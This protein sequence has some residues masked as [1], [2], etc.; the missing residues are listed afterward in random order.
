MVIHL[1]IPNPDKPFDLVVVGEINPD[2]ILSGNITPAFGQVE[3]MIEGAILT[4]GSSSAIFA[5]GAARL[6]LKVAFVGKIG[7]DVFGQFMRQQLAERGIDVAGM[8]VDP[9]IRTGLSVILSRGVDRAILT[10]SG[11]I[12]ALRYTEIDLGLLD[13]ARHLHLG[14]YFMLDALR[15][16]VPRLFAEAHNRGLTISLD[17]NYDPTEYWDGGLY[18]SLR[19]VDIFL[20]NETELCAIAGSQDAGIALERLAQSVPT[21]A[22][23]LGGKGALARQ[24]G[25]TADV[26]A[27]PIDVVDTTGAGDTFDAGFVYGYLHGWDLGRTLRLACACGSLS[28]RAA[29]GTAAQPTV[30]EAEAAL[31]Y[32]NQA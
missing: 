21:I 15:P 16:D 9:A 10:Y 20:P 4:I 19:Y 8:A 7:D 2:L 23:K 17:T 29:G 25:Q 22:V 5:C 1:P 13:K 32:Y 18:E 12:A 28:A 31:R 14:A 26:E 24:H 11:S 3:Q 6:G 27:L 30:A